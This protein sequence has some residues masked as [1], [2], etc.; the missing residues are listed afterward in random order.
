LSSL[1]LD[2]YTFVNRMR[3]ESGDRSFPIWI[4]VNPKYPA[5]IF[6]IWDPIM[7]EI[8]DKVY[9]K[10]H[11]RIN[12]R[13]IFIKNAVSDIVRVPNTKIEADVA[14]SSMKLRD[15]VLEYQP[16]LLITFGTIT[17][18]FVRRVF[19]IKP[20]NGPKYWSTS[21]L[22]DE[23]ERSIANFDINRTNCI[24]LIRQITKTGKNIKGWEESNNNYYH[25]VASKIAEKIIENKDSLKIWI[26]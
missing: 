4:L 24:P 15:S 14:Q 9:R 11:A 17:N 19:D 12:S 21:N 25:D 26:E 1:L 6:N 3:K 10:L 18:E 16:K 22:G 8:Q 23:F 5:D 13:K 2:N 20:K 7:Y